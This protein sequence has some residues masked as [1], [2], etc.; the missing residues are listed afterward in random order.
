M[1]THA[2]CTMLPTTTFNTGVAWQWE[3][4]GIVAKQYYADGYLGKLWFLLNSSDATPALSEQ[5]LA[6]TC[7]NSISNGDQSSFSTPA[8][9]T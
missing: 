2:C 6:T 3:E 5:P 4:D 9:W 8:L 7:L 1:T